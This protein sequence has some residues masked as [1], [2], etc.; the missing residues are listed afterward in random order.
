MTG[1]EGDSG[2]RSPTTPEHKAEPKSVGVKVRTSK[3]FEN[4]LE[5]WRDLAKMLLEERKI[6]RQQAQHSLPSREEF[7]KEIEGRFWDTFDEVSSWAILR[8]TYNWFKERLK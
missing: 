2:G 7:E 5:Y 1:A 4:S 8:E 6:E 3:D